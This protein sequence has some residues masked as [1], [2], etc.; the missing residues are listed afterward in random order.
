MCVFV[1]IPRGEGGGGEGG[2]YK[3][4]DP[5]EGGGDVLVAQLHPQAVPVIQR[6]L[7]L[8]KPTCSVAQ[9]RCYEICALCK[10]SRGIP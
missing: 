3:I 4:T 1:R 7:L 8:L 5:T 9:S 2:A 6:M 10:A